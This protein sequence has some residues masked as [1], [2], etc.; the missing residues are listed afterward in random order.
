MF[1]ITPVSKP[2]NSPSS[3]R[4]LSE[5]TRL[6]LQR[7]LGMYKRFPQSTPKP[8]VSTPRPTSQNPETTNTTIQS[9]NLYA[10]DQK[11][12]PQDQGFLHQK[13][14]ILLLAARGTE[15]SSVGTGS[16]KSPHQP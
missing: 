14:E 9:G 1:V 12:M 10:T 16:V 11:W 3:N 6:K 15:E 4:D 13:P 5:I 7:P 2:P 8:P